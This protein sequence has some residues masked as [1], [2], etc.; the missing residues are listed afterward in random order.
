[1][2]RWDAVYNTLMD[3]SAG[4]VQQ[5]ESSVRFGL[6]LYSHVYDDDNLPDSDCP[7]IASVAPAISNFTAIENVY[8]GEGPLDETP[9]GAALAQVALDLDAV[10]EPG[11]KII[12]L[13][14]DGEPDTCDQPNPQN[15]QEEALAAAEMAYDLGIST[16]IIAV[17]NQVSENHQQQMANVGTGRARDEDPGAPYY[18]ALDPDSL[19]DAFDAIIGGFVSCE[20]TITGEVDPNQACTGRVEIDGQVLECSKDWRLND[21]TTLELLGE[22]CDTLQ[23]GEEHVVTANFPCGAV[24]VP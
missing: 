12:V 9:T 24:Y 2:D 5:L 11:A 6:A 3:P 13:A 22:A 20:F 10:T 16:F 18:Q 15:G 23:D 4:I 17:G 21:P 8:K 7:L 14:T 19:V 1:M